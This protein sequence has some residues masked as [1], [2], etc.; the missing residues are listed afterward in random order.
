[1][2]SFQ[3]VEDKIEET[4]FF[5]EKMENI[6][7]SDVFNIKFYFSAFVSAARSITFT[8]QKS[9]KGMEG[10]D[11]WYNSI[12]KQLRMDNVAQ[13]FH[14]ARNENQKE[15]LY[16]INSGSSHSGKI[17]FYF[18][19]TEESYISDDV[20]TMS[21]R[22]FCFLLKIVI[23]CYIKYGYEIDPLLYYSHEGIK[24]RKQTIEDIEKEIIGIQRWTFLPGCTEE[25][26][27]NLLLRNVALPKIDYIFIK[28][29]KCNRYGKQVNGT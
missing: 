11:E 16:H 5:L 1:M 15:G 8:I 21:N 13:F 24:S 3:I 10:F 25:Q 2:Y 28:R 23:E 26:R 27:L 9:L 4:N 29:L 7:F 22:Y 18:D 6:D 20:C 17:L 12:Q 14:L 19:K